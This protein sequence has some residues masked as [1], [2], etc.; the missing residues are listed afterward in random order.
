M[1]LP[2]ATVLSAIPL[3]K[4]STGIT[5]RAARCGSFVRE[6]L[7]VSDVSYGGA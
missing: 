6:V 5:I 2:L 4:T 3:S 7:G 1:H